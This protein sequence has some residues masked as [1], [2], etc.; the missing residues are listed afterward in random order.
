MGMSVKATSRLATV[1]VGETWNDL[2][3][4][5]SSVLATAALDEASVSF[6]FALPPRAVGPLWDAL[7]C[8]THQP[9]PIPPAIH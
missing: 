2:L 5:A 7:L 9:R 8:E 6:S 1:R 4:L 3:V